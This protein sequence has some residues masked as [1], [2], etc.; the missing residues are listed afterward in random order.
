MAYK[1]PD[2]IEEITKTTEEALDLLVGIDLRFLRGVPEIR[3]T[4]QEAR[5]QLLSAAR[6]LRNSLNEELVSAE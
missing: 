1:N 4:L 2:K 3:D 5:S 6:M